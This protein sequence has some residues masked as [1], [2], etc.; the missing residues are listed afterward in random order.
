[1]PVKRRWGRKRK[2]LKQAVN[3]R[4]LVLLSRYLRGDGK[5]QTL[6]PFPGASEGT[7]EGTEHPSRT[8][9]DPKTS[10]KGGGKEA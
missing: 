6:I 9:S 2:S 8:E 10:S 1:M 3:D 4:A 7:E 5:G